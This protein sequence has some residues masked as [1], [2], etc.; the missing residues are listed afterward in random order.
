MVHKIKGKLYAI[1]EVPN[2]RDE[3]VISLDKLIEVLYSNKRDVLWFIRS[4][5]SCIVL[6]QENRK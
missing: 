6:T 1:T 4:K 2:S 3:N 5:E